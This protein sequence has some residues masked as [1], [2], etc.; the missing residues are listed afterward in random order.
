M[1]PTT[2]KRFTVSAAA[3]KRM[4][5]HIC[6]GFLR[7]GEAAITVVDS[8]G[9]DHAHDGECPKWEKPVPTNWHIQGSNR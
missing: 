9:A 5:C 6:R 2:V 3:H 8:L 7:E 4:R 1:S